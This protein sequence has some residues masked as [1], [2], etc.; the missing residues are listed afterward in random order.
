MKAVITGHTSGIGKAVYELLEGAGFNVVGLSRSN[1]YN[2]QEADKVVRKVISEDPDIFINNAYHLKSQT[3]ILKKTYQEF[4]F[5]DKLIVNICSVAALIPKTHEDYGME[6]ASDKR[7]QRKFCEEVNFE[8]SKKDFNKVKCK[9]TNL[10]FD[11]VKT[12]FK[13]KHD[14]R[15]YPNLSPQDVA[16]I[17]F[18]VIINKNVCIREMSFHST[19]PPEILQ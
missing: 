2:I 13:S 14:K 3:D 6:Y 17:I 4:K 16:N 7:A 9:L 12:N 18:F 15:K 10:N 8:Y 11:Y 19:N 5:Q 1:G